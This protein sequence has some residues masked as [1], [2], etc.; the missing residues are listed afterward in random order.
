MIDEKNAIIVRTEVPL[1]KDYHKYQDVLRF[2]FCYACAYCSITEIEATGI[3][4]EIDHYNPK[5]NFPQLKSDYSNLMW[6]CRICNRY[7]SDYHPDAEDL[8]NGYV[9]LRIDKCDPRDHL[10]LDHDALLFESKTPTGEF[11]IQ[12][13]ELNRNQ[14]KR[15]REYRQRFFNATNYIAFGIHDLLSLDLDNIHPK[16]R[17]LFQK[18]KR[19]VMQREYEVTDSIKLLIRDFAHSTLLDKDPTKKE[20]QKRRKEY[21]KQYKA[22]LP[23][24]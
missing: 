12:R 1:E 24:D 15:L 8:R 4:F 20:R 6:S 3:G 17:L 19:Y 22:I 2:D 13:L 11:N 10:E 16:Y 21:L 5:D 9:I 18:I 14:L 23:L 7:K